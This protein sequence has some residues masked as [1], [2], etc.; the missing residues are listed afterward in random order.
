MIIAE[1]LCIVKMLLFMEEKCNNPIFICIF[2]FYKE[3]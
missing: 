3:K 2:A 1:E